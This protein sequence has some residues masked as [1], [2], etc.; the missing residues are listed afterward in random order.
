M[1]TL[2]SHC[3]ELADL[4]KAKKQT[5]AVAESSTAGLI[6]SCL[7]AVPGASAYYL[8]GCVIYTMDARRNILGLADEVL[9]AQKPV[10]EDYVTLCAETVRN[11]VNATWGVGELGIAGPTGSRYGHDAGISVVGVSG[12]VS[13]ARKIETGHNDRERNMWA[14]ADGALALLLEA[15]KQ[16]G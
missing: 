14:F 2:A 6:S 3:E 7:L 11:Q 5:V 13:L 9:K 12:P 1:T 10:T 8:G 15:V 4:L 16:E